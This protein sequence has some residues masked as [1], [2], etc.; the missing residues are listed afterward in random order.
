MMI[1]RL[2][3]AASCLVSSAS[4]FSAIAS[5]APASAAVLDGMRS[6]PLVRASDASPVLI[7]DE[8]RSGTPFG[9]A[10]EVAVLAFLRHYG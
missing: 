8:W 4:A 7:S 3:V 9:L 1:L 5:P 10:D 6:T 2:V